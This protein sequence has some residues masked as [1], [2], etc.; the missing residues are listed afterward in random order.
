MINVSLDDIN[1]GTRVSLIGKG[2]RFSL[3]DYENSSI[4]I[5]IEWMTGT[6]IRK[7]NNNIFVSYVVLMDENVRNAHPK[8]KCSSLE[9]KIAEGML[10]KL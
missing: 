7:L 3:H 10:E 6:V 5:D 1:K 4:L 9:W 2:I 8:L